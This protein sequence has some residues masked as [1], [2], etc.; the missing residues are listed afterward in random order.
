[1]PS[2]PKAPSRCTWRQKGRNPRAIQCRSP[3][4]RW[5]MPGGIL[6]AVS[7]EFCRASG[8]TVRVSWSNRP[9]NSGSFPSARIRGFS[10]RLIS[11]GSTDTSRAPGPG[12]RARPRTRQ[13]RYRRPPDPSPRHNAWSRAIISTADDCARSHVTEHATLG[14]SRRSWAVG[15]VP[16]GAAPGP[17]GVTLLDGSPVLV[18][19]IAEARDYTDATLQRSA[20]RD[21]A[22]G[23]GRC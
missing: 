20:R 10:H 19:D 12:V 22:I 5:T 23:A 4:E 21:V 15:V 3:G 7:W 1:M 18:V 8:S 9:E 2:R 13:P 17:S 6:A 14:R 16:T 11:P